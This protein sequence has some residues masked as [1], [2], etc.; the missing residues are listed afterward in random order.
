[1]RTRCSRVAVSPPLPSL[2]LAERLLQASKQSVL[3]TQALVT[4][5]LQSEPVSNQV[6]SPKQTGAGVDTAAGNLH[7]QAQK[8]ILQKIGHS[9]KFSAIPAVPHTLGS[10]VECEFG[11]NR[12]RRIE[13][14]QRSCKLFATAVFIVTHPE[15]LLHP[16]APAVRQPPINQRDIRKVFF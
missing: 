1:V 16:L 7:N 10:T 6:D 13:L 5:N 9:Q 3:S 14:S 11:L 4:G 12:Y 2:F 8:T 15:K